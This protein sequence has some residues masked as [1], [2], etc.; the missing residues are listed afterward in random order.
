[1]FCRIGISSHHITISTKAII[2][3]QIAST[4]IQNF[5]PIDLRFLIFSPL[6]YR[7]GHWQFLHLET[8]E[9]KQKKNSRL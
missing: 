6:R 1:M 9:K 8:K 5:F 4:Q 2:N 3:Q 7:N